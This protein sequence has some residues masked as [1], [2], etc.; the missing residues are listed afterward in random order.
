MDD[1]R[2]VLVL[3]ARDVAAT[4]QCYETI[5]LALREEKHGDG[6]V[7]YAGELPGGCILEIYPMR[8]GADAKPCQSAMLI[9]YTA[10]FDAVVAG[11]K[12]MELKPRDPEV[13]LREDGLRATSVRDP[14]GFLIRLLE[15]PAPT[16]H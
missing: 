4:R 2:S 5:G 16:V 8:A 14:D 9:L 7:H 6:P 3:Y 12:A 11:L 15:R 10:D 1:F 13:Y